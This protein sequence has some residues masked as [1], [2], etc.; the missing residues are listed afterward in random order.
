MSIRLKILF[1]ICLTFLAL[2]GT[3]Y[4]TFQWFLKRDAV[5]AEGKS[6]TRD[7]T[8]L[9]AALDD[10]IAGMDATLNDWAG[11]DD[12]YEFISN[13]DPGYID[14]NLPNTTF[15]NLGVELM[16]FINNSGQ[17]VF[18]KMVELDSEVEIPIPESLTSQLQA[19][20]LLLSHKN[21]GDRLAGF[22][23]LPEGPMM[24]ASQPILTSLDE[25]PINGT[26]I[27]GLFLDQTEIV[28]LSQKTLLSISV[29]PYNEDSMPDDVAVARNSLVGLN[30]IFVAP[31]SETIVS[32]YTLINDVYGN[33]AL[34]LRVDAPRDAFSQAKVSMRYL[35]LA[36]AAIGLVLALVI[37]VLFERLVITRLTSL[38][39]SVKKIGS[40]GTASSRVEAHGNDE[41]FVL[42]TSVNSML[43]SLESSRTTERAS[44]DRLR[45]SEERYRRAEIIGH[46]GSWEYNLQTNRFWG[47]DEAKRIY[48]FDPKQ[49]DFSTDEV[50]SCIPERERVHQALVDLVESGKEYNLEFEIRPRNSSE[51]RIIA[52]VAELQRDE[53]GNP[54]SVVGVIQD[55][56]G[57]KQAEESNK[58]YIKFLESLE[59]IDKVIRQ[60]SD[61]ESLLKNV[62]ERVFITFGCDRAWLF[63]PCDP[64][65]PTFRVPIE[66]CR[67]EYP[68]ANAMDLEVPMDVSVANDLREAL[69]SDAPL[70]YAFGTE[71]PVNTLTARQFAVQSQMFMAIHPKIGKPW[72]FGMHQCS[73]PRIWTDDERA[74]FNE[75]GRRVADGLSS[76]LIFRD[77]RESEE[78]FRSLF[79][80]A[81]IGM[82]R[83]TPDGKILLANPAL[84]T[85]LGY[86]SF[87][88]LSQRDLEA[89]GYEP[90]YERSLFRQRIESNGEVKGLESVW[91]RKD[92]KSI[93]VRE[94]A[95]VIRNMKG[96][97]AYYEGLVE[98]ITEGKLAE[99]AL[100]NSQEFLQ[101]VV[102]AVHTPIFYKDAD[103]RYLGCNK[104]FEDYTGIPQKE[105]L[106]KS[107]FDITSRDLAE[108][109]F[110][111]DKELFDHPGVQTYESTVMASDGRRRYV[112]FS[113]ATFSN[114]D[115]RIGGLVGSIF[116]ITERKQAEEALKESEEKYRLLFE[117]NPI[118]MW[119]YD[120]E[121]LRF[122]AVNEA[123][124]MKY[125]YSKDEFLAMTL[126]DIRP[127]EEMPR[128]MQ[129]VAEATQKVQASSPWVHRA[130]DGITFSVEIHSHSIE[131]SGRP[132]RLVMSNDITE[133]K[134]AEEEIRQLNAELEQRVEA[135][136]RELRE[137]QEKL[138]R[139]EKLA[140]L[141]QLAGGVGHE[142][143]NPLAVINNAVYFLKLVQPN[144]DETIKDYLSMIE[145][146]THTAEK[147]INDLLDFACIKS[148]DREAIDIPSLVQRVLERYTAPPSVSVA[149]EFSQDLPP[150]F[151][152]PHQIEQVLGNLVVNACQAMPEGGKL[153]IVSQVVPSGDHKF[154]TIG[155]SDTG[156]G[157]HPENM[158]KLFEPLF[159]T[160]TKG[161]GLGLAVSRKLIEANDGRIEVESEPG[162]GSTFTVYL[163][164]T[165][166][167]QP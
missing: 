48:G 93:F 43:D 80:N 98:D 19:G 36:L 65:A 117:S 1:V 45:I 126:K 106:G 153:K 167:I 135:R 9:L 60:E 118:P 53:R 158:N 39:S 113:K 166:G 125:G 52:S 155:V 123:A 67:P 119:V 161:I 34:I 11:W 14:S 70:T 17:I 151:A 71:R 136:T 18:G 8:R 129:N 23:V 81:T 133:R 22:I 120:L 27:M 148:V 144:A 13:G 154:V 7:I 130:K 105:L 163:P 156:V 134:R 62:M 78:R 92:G 122:L 140:V 150:V 54:L 143:R 3:L 84:V 115:G 116:D 41:I 95:R 111:K 152:D 91:T 46:V 2:V 89:E 64:D 59:Q 4:F 124:V 94:S 50:E 79:E 149:L 107:V 56:T 77:L 72:V 88:E 99:I 47:S 114:A 112:V 82:Y 97:V 61:I 128:L 141:G 15:D 32:G 110:A 20:S 157:I 40:Q 5:I 55:I 103:G 30:P 6:T 57:R 42:A 159:T 90:G 66:V 142:L 108:R 68:G 139:Q 147:I 69:A 104:A 83:T 87:A 16:L 127:S 75:I 102:D 10:Q 29:Y 74:L 35:G 73:H 12:T 76:M 33:P 146:E 160:K 165:Q 162:Q 101:R 100:R 137:T 86:S 44:E 131:Y 25:G 145:K 37:M 51:P 49:A 63:Y 132:A 26:L 85:M 58:L 96:D 21:P 109:Y 138:V 24:I 28:K 31:Q 164:S 38:T 121:S